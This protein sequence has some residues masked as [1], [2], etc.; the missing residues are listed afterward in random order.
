MH[1]LLCLLG[2]FCLVQ[3]LFVLFPAM[4]SVDTE[5]G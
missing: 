3:F 2:V 4:K 1:R 5:V